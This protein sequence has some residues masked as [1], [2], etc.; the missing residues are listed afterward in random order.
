MMDLLWHKE[1]W[2]E[3]L[4]WQT[5]DA[6]TLKRLNTL[7]KIIM[8][9][10]YETIGKPEPLRGNYAGL[11]SVRIDKKNRLVFRVKD[12]RVEIIEC[13]THYKEK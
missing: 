8:R 7:L 3:Y 10:G 5:Q 2:E 9:G 11:W 13:R 1:A 12:D 6:K 4:Y